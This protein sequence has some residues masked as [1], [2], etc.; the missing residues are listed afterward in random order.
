MKFLGFRPK[1]QTKGYYTDGHNRADVTEYRDNV[2]L[3]RM[4]DYERRM[5]DYSGDNMDNIIPPSLGENEKRVELI[6]HDESTF[7]SC[8]G[9]PIMW[10]ENGKN[11]LLPKTNGTCCGFCCDCHGFFSDENQRSFELF[12]AGKNRM[13]WFTNKDLVEQFER[14][15]PLIKRLHHDCDIVIAFDNSMTHHAKVPDGLDVGNLKLSDGMSSNTKVNMRPGWFIDRSGERIVQSMQLPDGT[16]KGIK[17]I[18]RERGKHKNTN[19][20]DLTL[21]CVV[22]REKYTETARAEHMAN[23]YINERCCASYVLSHEDDFLEQEEWLT[24]VVH[25]AGF[26]I[27]FYPMITLCIDTIL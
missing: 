15:T 2:F 25:N 5:V 3:P 18:L 17:T 13:G 6:T 11:K 16:Q 1:L 23:G 19:G 9:K 8:E 22:C 7:Y 4:V 21:Q 26:E 14:L 24:Q 20:H 10:M 12:E 27:L